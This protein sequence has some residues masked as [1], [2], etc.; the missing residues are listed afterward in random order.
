MYQSLELKF[1][2]D[3]YPKAIRKQVHKHLITRLFTAGL[4]EQG[5]G[6]YGFWVLF[7]FQSVRREKATD[8]I[9]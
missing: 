8:K 1:A 2:S 4:L 9:G 7:V 6:S 3:V 5:N